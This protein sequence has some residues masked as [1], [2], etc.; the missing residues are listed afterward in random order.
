GTRIMGDLEILSPPDGVI[1]KTRKISRPRLLRYEMQR[2]GD[3]FLLLI[4]GFFGNDV[5]GNIQSNIVV[6]DFKEALQITVIERVAFLELPLLCHSRSVGRWQ[7]VNRE[8]V[9]AVQIS[10]GHAEL[11]ADSSC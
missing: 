7:P 11:V 4:N 10:L 9:H 6:D 5:V 8:L 1:Y 2:D 3:G